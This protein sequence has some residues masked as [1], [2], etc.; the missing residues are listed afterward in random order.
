M[1]SFR[2][3][4]PKWWSRG[5]SDSPWGNVAF[6]LISS[7]FLMSLC[8]YLEESTLATPC[9][10][11]TVLQK[12]LPGSWV[13]IPSLARVGKLSPCISNFIQFHSD[14]ALHHATQPVCG[15]TESC[16]MLLLQGEVRSRAA[17]GFLHGICEQFICP[18]PI[19]LLFLSPARATKS[20]A[21]Q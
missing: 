14:S 11:T 20:E 21:H 17:N 13:Q 2:K 3:Q 8:S 6:V 4:Q 19:L 10:W 15:S 16:K 1:K 7:V 18:G 9:L 12:W 5:C